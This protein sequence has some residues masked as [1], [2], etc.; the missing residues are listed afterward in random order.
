MTDDWALLS[1]HSPP[2]WSARG[3]ICPIGSKTTPE[4]FP[5]LRKLH[6]WQTFN[7]LTVLCA[8]HITHCLPFKSPHYNY[9]VP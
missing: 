5:E 7:V 6:L 2:E 8:Q 9:F 4:K 3:T 1:K